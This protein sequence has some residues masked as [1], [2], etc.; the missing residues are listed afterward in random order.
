MMK[1]WQS[2]C[3][4]SKSRIRND[5]VEVVKSDMEEANIQFNVEQISSTSKQIFKKIVK[6]QSQIAFL[7][8]LNKEKMKLSKGNNLNYPQLKLQSYLKSNSNLTSETMKRIMKI[9]LRDIPVKCNFPGAFSDNKCVAA[10]LC[11]KSESNEHLFSCEYLAAG[12]E[13]TENNIKYEHIFSDNVQVQEQIAN[14][15]FSRLEK[16]NRL[17]NPSGKGPADPRR[18]GLPSLGIKKTRRQQN[19]TKKNKCKT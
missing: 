10:P 12:N 13:M 16:R 5:W 17:I 6:E 15:M 2:K 18:R 19:K 8:Q 9:R 14:I 11:D 3:C 7:N 4:D 1:I